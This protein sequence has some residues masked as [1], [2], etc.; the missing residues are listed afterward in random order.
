MARFVLTE[1]GKTAVNMA[2]SGGTKITIT[3]VKT[4]DSTSLTTDTYPDF[5]SIVQTVPPSS[6]SYKSDV[7]TALVTAVFTNT[8]LSQAYTIR[9]VG[10]YAKCAG[11]YTMSTARLFGYCILDSAD[12]MP[13]PTS[14][15]ISYTYQLNTKVADTETITI[16]LI[17][18]AYAS[19]TDFYELTNLVHTNEANSIT[20]RLNA[21]VESSERAGYNWVQEVSVQ[22]MTA[23][24]YISAW[25]SSGTYNGQ[26][27]VESAANK[28]RL[29]FVTKPGTSVYLNVIY[30]PT[31]S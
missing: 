19:A 4:S 1:Y 9:A 21:T 31:Y 14:E 28:L 2:A 25:I 24:Y 10:L 15:P 3:A 22:G 11:D 16:E 13:L 8:A 26:F 12:S 20:V 18:G 23:D 29:W 30:F 27:L 17:E 7:G 6:I 5:T